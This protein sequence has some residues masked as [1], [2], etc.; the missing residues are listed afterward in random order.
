[1][2]TPVLATRVGGVPEIVSDGENGLLVE[3]NDSVAFAAALTRYLGDQELQARLQ[4]AAAA[5]VARFAA[6]SVYGEIER[7]LEAAAR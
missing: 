3:P 2:G 4:R 7:I 6:D 1:M 5:S